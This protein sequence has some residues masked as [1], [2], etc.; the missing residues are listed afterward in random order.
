MHPGFD[1]LAIIGWRSPVN[2][3]VSVRGSFSDLDSHCDNGVLWSIDK[4]SVTMQSGD[5]PNGGAPMPFYFRVRVKPDDV[6]NFIVDPKNG[7]YACDTTGID[8]TIAR[9]R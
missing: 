3:V 7:D 1:R 8:V 9:G 6:L 4:G 5:L 2:G